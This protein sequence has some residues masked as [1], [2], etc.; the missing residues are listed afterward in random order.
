MAV[1]CAMVYELNF[2]NCDCLFISRTR[3]LH[4]YGYEGVSKI[5]RTG[6]L[7]RELKMEQL[8]ATMCSYIAIL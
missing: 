4:T 6:R 8:S 5:F 3:A 1:F 7:E 2:M